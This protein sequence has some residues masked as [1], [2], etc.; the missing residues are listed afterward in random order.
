MATGRSLEQGPAD[1]ARQHR[2]ESAVMRR[3]H[4]EHVGLLLVGELEKAARGGGRHHRPALEVVTGSR[5]EG[6]LGLLLEP[7]Q[8]LPRW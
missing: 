6:F 7:R 3:A 1:A 4:H 8:L 2:P 5:R